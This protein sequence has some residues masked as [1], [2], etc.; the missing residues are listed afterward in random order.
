MKK[1]G[2][3]LKVERLYIETSRAGNSVL[4]VDFRDN[5]NRLYRHYI[6]NNKKSNV[7]IK[8]LLLGSGLNKT[9]DSILLDAYIPL[10][11]RDEIKDIQEYIAGR[12]YKVVTVE[13]DETW[14]NKKVPIVAE[15]YSVSDGFH[16]LDK[17]AELFERNGSWQIFS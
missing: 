6:S 10:L 14:T 11:A 8:Q 9:V 12:L 1:F 7:W 17:I 4:V 2:R 3:Y 15:I 5:N 16:K 13:N